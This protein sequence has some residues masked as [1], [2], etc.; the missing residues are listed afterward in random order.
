MA[1]GLGE[2]RV[3]RIAWAT[4]VRTVA[5]LAGLA[6]LAGFA[7][8]FGVVPAVAVSPAQGLGLIFAGLGLAALAAFVDR[9]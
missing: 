3:R 4:S 9:P 1:E 7:N 6:G 8:V 2:E 5:L